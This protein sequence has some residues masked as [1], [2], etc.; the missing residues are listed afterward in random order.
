MRGPI[1]ARKILRRLKVPD[2][3]TPEYAFPQI[4]SDIRT[5]GA[6]AMLVALL[7]GTPDNIEAMDA[8]MRANYPWLAPQS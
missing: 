5:P 8:L 3:R 2:M 1:R 7:F 6:A 4:I